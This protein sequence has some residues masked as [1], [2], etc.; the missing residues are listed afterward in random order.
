MTLQLGF[1]RLSPF[2]FIPTV[3]FFSTTMR[4]PTPW[5]IHTLG[6]LSQ[7]FHSCPQTNQTIPAL[8]LRESY[9]FQWNNH[10][11]D[12]EVRRVVSVQ[13]RRV[14]VEIG[15]P[16]WCISFVLVLNNNQLSWLGVPFGQV[17][18]SYVLPS[19]PSDSTFHDPG[20]F[21]SFHLSM[22]II[23]WRVNHR[24]LRAF[25]SIAQ[26]PRRLPR[27]HHR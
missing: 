9:I 12:G 21:F 26:S 14:L 7:V 24:M 3:H 18:Q 5:L 16:A 22:H 2:R 8:R 27:T 4:Q 19:F 13:F 1:R 25:W 11:F 20:E 6:P 15:L 17:V 23:D 10:R